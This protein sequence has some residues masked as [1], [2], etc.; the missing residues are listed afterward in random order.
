MY[1]YIYIYTNH[2][3]INECIKQR[4][5]IVTFLSNPNKEPDVERHF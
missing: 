1:I 5:G 3:G 2:I 4:Q